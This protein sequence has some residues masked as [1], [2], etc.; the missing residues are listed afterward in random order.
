MES[1]L[2]KNT[3]IIRKKDRELYSKIYESESRMNISVF[4]S[5]NGDIVPSVEVNS[6]N[7]F[8]HSRF[9]PYKEAERFIAGIDP[10]KFDLFIVFGFGFGYH[11][12]L[13][14]KK[15]NPDALILII[16]KEASMVREALTHRDLALLVSDERVVMLIDP[17]E[18]QIAETLKGKSSKR[19]SF[20]SHRGSFQVSPEYYN[21]IRQIVKSYLSVKEV[22]IAT[23]S[24]FE[25]TWTANI[26]RNIKEFVRL[27]G[28]DMFYDKFRGMPALI[29]GAG[30]SLNKSLEFIKD[31]QDRIIIICVDTSYRIL[32]RNGISPHFCL[33][34]DPQIINAR[35]FEDCTFENTVFVTDPAVHP[36]VFRL[37][38]GRISTVGMAFDM[39][40]WVEEFTGPKGELAYGG[41]VTTNAYDFAKRIGASPVIMAGQDLAFTDR[42]AHARGSYLDE[43]VHLRTDRFYNAHMKNRFQL[44]ALPKIKVKGIRSP[45]VITNQKLMIFLNWFEKRNDPDLI[46]ATWDGAFIKGVN[47]SSLNEIALPDLNRNIFDLIQDLYSE[48]QNDLSSAASASNELLKKCRQMSDELDSLLPVFERAVKLS[49]EMAGMMKENRKDSKLDYILKKLSETDKILESKNTLKDLIGFTIQRIIHT[50]TEGYEIDENDEKIS[51]EELV[52]KKS[53][54][55]YKGIL[56]GSEFNSKI[57][58]KMITLLAENSWIF[59]KG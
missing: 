56:E 18:D 3:G 54:Y 52:A 7:L 43:E 33:T 31:N 12:E 44:T 6:R 17:D 21:N 24:R 4:T 50:I 16:D 22:N 15:I 34:V 59:N 20:L 10:S 14:L 26:A 51:N 45:E 29:A 5:K 39:M 9:D 25:K 55:F 46:N 37:I 2:N 48:S 41:S 36:S 28:A 57:L 53:H 27:P 13:L 11:I 49:D 35:Y 58:K 32:Q 19:V 47:H 30:P 38:N 23:L 8:I 40:K 1:F 42:L